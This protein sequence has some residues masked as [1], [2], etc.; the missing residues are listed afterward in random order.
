MPGFHLS[1]GV[2]A[3]RI[4]APTRIASTK[5][6]IQARPEVI[7]STCCKAYPSPATAMHNI[8]PGSIRGKA[9]VLETKMGATS[10]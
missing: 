8:S 2:Q 10:V 7:S 1:P 4:A 5:A 6:S 3:V 9:L